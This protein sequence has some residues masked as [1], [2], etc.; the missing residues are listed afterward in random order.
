MSTNKIIIFYVEDN[1]SYM[2]ESFKGFIEAKK[3]IDD[4]NHS[5][6]KQLLW[7]VNGYLLNITPDGEF[8]G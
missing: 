7:V 3:K 4:I 8:Y 5:D 6:N 2:A 1:V